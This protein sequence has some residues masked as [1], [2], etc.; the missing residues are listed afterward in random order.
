MDIVNPEDSLERQNEKLQ[1]IVN[2][3]M[4]RAEQR[5]EET[6]YSYAQFERTAM[7]EGQVRERTVNLERVLDL[8]NE[9]NRQLAEAN[10]ETEQAWANLKEATESIPDGLALFDANDR[11]VLF[12]RQFCNELPDLG[13]QLKVGLTFR[14]Y[15]ALASHS[16]Y[17]DLSAFRSRDQWIACRLQQHASQRVEFN[18]VCANGCMIRIHSR[19]TSTGSTVILHS[20]VTDTV[21][22]ERDR[23]NEQQV[24]QLRNTLDHLDLGVCIFD[25]AGLLVGRN[26]RLDSLLALPD[27]D[28]PHGLTASGVIDRLQ[29]RIEFSETFGFGQLLQWAETAG[30]R[31]PI[32][33]V[34]KQGA[35]TILNVFC[36][37]M[38]DHGFL[39]SFRDVTAEREAGRTLAE[40]N[41]MLECRVRERTIELDQALDEARRA[42]ASK[43][44]FVAAASHD[45]AQ[46]LSAAKLYI[47][48]LADGGADGV[49]AEHVVNVVEKAEA[50]LQS[51]DQIIEALL[52]ISRFDS[53]EASIDRQPVPL[54][55]VLGALQTELIQQARVKGL[56]F[57]VVCSS[58]VV[59]SDPGYLRRIIRNFI[60]NAVRY[61]E[62]GRVLVGVRRVG[63][64]ARIEVWDTGPGI[65]P[66]DQ[67][68]IFEEFRQ[69]DQRVGES[70]G[71]GLGLAIVER[72]CKALAHP[73]N[74]WSEPGRGSCFSI[75]LPIVNIAVS[76]LEC[77]PPSERPATDAITGVIVL[78]VVTDQQ[79]SSALSILIEG[80]GGVAL[81]VTSKFEALSLL[82]D[83]DLVPDVLILDGHLGEGMTGMNAYDAITA[84]LG[85][86]PARI[87]T[88]DRSKELQKL[89]L[90]RQLEIMPK[91]IDPAALASFL[92]S[93][94]SDR[95]G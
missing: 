59:D 82:A 29:E 93:V 54:N 83:V 40:V 4:H 49:N 30:D 26:R 7:L 69:L 8:L 77:V 34:V 79:L 62:H 27:A 35:Q 15:L 67:N 57:S 41:E 21:R 1:K 33:F 6:G 55:L 24:I 64:K 45:L 42:N 65:S 68:I 3:L 44:R 36:Q 13:V 47:A 87:I 23:L 20:D 80:W 66:Q 22:Q 61:T 92:T 94:G 95:P 16:A 71:L 70:E 58:L 11:L 14:D 53:K 38:A 2:A 10:D 60:S 43:S 32:E 39:F 25:S 81:E 9:S 51:A 90:E 37:E 46:P 88:A 84:L 73:L 50:A 12:N 85:V 56:E 17:L 18:L 75:D 86:L 31:P 63:G 72:A 52:D 28:L 91:P 78:L 89:C 74:L 48:S 76:P 5:S 19:K